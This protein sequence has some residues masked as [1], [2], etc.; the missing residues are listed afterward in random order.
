MLRLENALN[1]FTDAS[2]KGKADKNNGNTICA[3]AVAVDGLGG[4]IGE[5]QTFIQNA[6]NNIGELN[7]IGLGFRLAAENKGKYTTINIFSDSKISVCGFRDW[8]LGWINRSL[9]GI[10]LQSTT[11]PVANQNIIL[12][13]TDEIITNFDPNKDKVNLFHVNSHIN[14]RSIRDMNKATKTFMNNLYNPTITDRDYYLDNFS[15]IQRWNNYIDESTR[16]SFRSQQYGVCYVPQYEMMPNALSPLI[17][18]NY[19]IYHRILHG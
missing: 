3:G 17:F 9:D 7:A 4:R 18:D 8:M 5:Y 1:I 19:N 11:G 2:V 13:I 14:V 15:F 12:R 6:T 16:S 10:T